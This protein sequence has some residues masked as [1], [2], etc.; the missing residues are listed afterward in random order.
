MEAG[1]GIIVC[2]PGAYPP[3]L[4][5][6]LRNLAETCASPVLADPLSGLRFGSQ[7]SEW[8][9]CHYDAFLRSKHTRALLQPAWILRFGTP[10]VSRVLTEF[11]RD[12]DVPQ[13]LVAPRGDWMDPTHRAGVVFRAAEPGVCQ[14]LAGMVQR[15]P[16]AGWWTRLREKEVRAETVAAEL[17]HPVEPFEGDVI[18]DLMRCLPPGSLLLSGNSLPIRQLDT[19]SGHRRAPLRL[20]ANRGVSGIEGTV[21]TLLGAARVHT[22]GPVVGLL[23]DVSLVHDINGLLAASGID[24]TLIVVNNGGGGIFGYLPQASL[25]E[26]ERYWLTPPGLEISDIAR[27]H[28]LGYRRVERQAE[29]EAALRDSLA[30][31]G[32]QLIE[33]VIDRELS[34]QR[35]QFYWD[36][37]NDDAV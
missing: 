30:H 36:A 37:V 20:L 10:P 11:I 7:H 19:W 24:A 35:Q 25:P 17:P 28:R 29:F 6:A 33:V 1:T 22:T 12:C 32:V 8:V 27:L 18:R 5:A 16:A 34:M 3:G 21:S 2:G 31:T 13:A 23:G 9:L 14:A 4:G 15:R 26:F